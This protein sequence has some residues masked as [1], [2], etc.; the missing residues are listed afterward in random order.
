MSWQ[1]YYRRRDALDRVI[2]DGLGVPAGFTDEHEVLRALHHRWTLRLAGRVEL[3]IETIA[4]DQDLDPVD[5]LRDAWQA[6]V[7]HDPALRGLLDE[8]AD[9]P[10]LRQANAAQ[11]A[12]LARAAGLTGPADD[13]GTQAAIGAAFLALVRTSPRR[14]ASSA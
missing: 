10:A 14:L 6:T 8:H 4:R 7:D 12:M 13:T 2:A 9:H 1:D 5:A 11:Q 3:A